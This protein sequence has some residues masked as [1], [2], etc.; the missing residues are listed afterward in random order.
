MET[1][2]RVGDAMSHK[3]VSVH[4]G[5][6]LQNCAR[7]MKEQKIGALLIIDTKKRPLGILT[8]KDLVRKGMRPTGLSSI[9]SKPSSVGKVG[10][11]AIDRNLMCRQPKAQYNAYPYCQ[12]R[13]MPDY[14]NNRDKMLLLS[15]IPSAK[16]NY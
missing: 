1:G 13:P 9:T 10:K 12:L 5:E 2:F 11:V 8:E 14:S 4:H 7:I 6:S 16:P 15:H 3:V